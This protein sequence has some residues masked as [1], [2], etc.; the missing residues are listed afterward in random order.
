MSLIVDIVS[1]IGSILSKQQATIASRCT[2]PFSQP[3]DA[4]QQEKEHA[5]SS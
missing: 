3:R 5:Y 2:K 1:W 4:A